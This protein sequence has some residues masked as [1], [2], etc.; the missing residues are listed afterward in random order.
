M[1]LRWTGALVPPLRL[2]LLDYG[3]S[4]ESAE[5]DREECDKTHLVTEI[6]CSSAMGVVLM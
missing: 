1:T 3:P 2:R 4:H 6:S 5:P